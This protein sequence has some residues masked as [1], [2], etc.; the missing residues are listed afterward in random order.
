LSSIHAASAAR[1]FVSN[2]RDD[3]V[4]VLDSGT[5]KIVKAI[6]VGKR[7]RGIV[8][9]PDFKEVLVCA[10]DDDRIDVIDADKLQVSRHLESGADP[11]L[12]DIDPRIRDLLLHQLF[13]S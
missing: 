9:T 2:E 10:G 13:I 4:T 11:E 5:L 12:L 7:P 3:T 1:I 8:I 6:P